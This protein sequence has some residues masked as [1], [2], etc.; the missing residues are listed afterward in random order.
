MTM[1]KAKFFF[2]LLLS[3]NL[4]MQAIIL[5]LAAAVIGSCSATDSETRIDYLGRLKRDLFMV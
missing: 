3:S 4:Q 5:L 2:K 1:M